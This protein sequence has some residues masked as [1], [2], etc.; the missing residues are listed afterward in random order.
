MVMTANDAVNVIYL[1]LSADGNLDERRRANVEAAVAREEGRTVWR[2]SETAKRTYGLVELPDA[3]DGSAISTAFGETT[4]DRPVI[5]LALYPAVTEALPA[6]REALGGPGRPAGVLATH[7]TVAGEII[8]WDPTVTDV[9]VLM[10]II[11]VELRRFAS[12]HTAEL[13]S[14][15]PPTLVAS[16]AA[17]GLHAPQV[18]PARILEMRIDGA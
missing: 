7:S 2:T 11:D 17:G 15:L 18:E 3:R 16:I 12:G 9:R 1:T 8:E 4:Y 13:L 5:A 14:P 10:G 6:L